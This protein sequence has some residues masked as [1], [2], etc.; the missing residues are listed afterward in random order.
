MAI[1]QEE[2]SGWT[3]AVVEGHDLQVTVLPGKGGDLCELVHRR[4]GVDVLFKAPWGLSPPGAPPRAGSDGHAFLENYEGGWQTL[5]PNTND[6]CT[7]AGLDLPFH[8]EVCAL[9]W[10]WSALGEDGLRLSVKCRLLPLRL[11]RELR[12][13]GAALTLSDTVTHTGDEPCHLVLGHHCVLGP[14]FLGDGCR[15][16]ADAGTIVTGSEAWEDTARLEPAQRSAWPVARLAGG[17][18]VDLRDVPGPEAG[19]HDD[20][21]L[22]D[23][24]QGRL[25]VESPHTGLRF[26]LSWD[27]AVFPWIVSWQAYG[28][29]HALPLA[30]SYALGVEPWVGGG[31]LEAALAAGEALRLDPGRSITTDVTATIEE[32]D[33]S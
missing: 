7:Y 16:E 1:R 13:D 27:A 12:L 20:V 17:G 33:A 14:P 3:A 22:T 10:S 26:R 6:P 11:E 30:G 15:L 29:A 4:T 18:E 9:P 8:G 5:L 2:R 32:L 28:G 23:L 21:F 25:S 19:S 24:R 31:N